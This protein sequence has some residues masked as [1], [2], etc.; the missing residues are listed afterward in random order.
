MNATKI[1]KFV[2][3]NFAIAVVIF[4][5]PGAYAQ[6]PD[7]SQCTGLK[8]QAAGLCKGGV[9]VGCDTD[10]TRP[11]CTSIETQFEELTGDPAPWACPCNFLANVPMNTDNWDEN[12]GMLFVTIGTT[13]D[14]S[15]STNTLGVGLQN[16]D[17]VQFTAILGVYGPDFDGG[18]IETPACIYHNDQEGTITV[19]TIQNV[20]EYDACFRATIAYARDLN[21]LPNFTV[22]DPDGCLSP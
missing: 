16:L 11:G 3:A 22:N 13:G 21:A 1:S 14:C 10:D 12:L 6:Q 8:G 15:P 7:F 20:E 9:A 2:A 5:T 4:V 17:F 18:T 19:K